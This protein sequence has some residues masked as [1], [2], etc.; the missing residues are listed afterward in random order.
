MARYLPD[1]S[2]VRL[3]LEPVELV[4]VVLTV[5]IL[6]VS[7]P[8]QVVSGGGTWK[9]A[10]LRTAPSPTTSLNVLTGIDPSTVSGGTER[11]FL[12]LRPRPDDPPPLP[13]QAAA[14]ALAVPVPMDIP[15]HVGRP[16][17]RRPTR[18]Q[19]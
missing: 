2:G 15:K 11:I 19:S 17:P 14:A 16:L 18:R 13:P 7:M 9:A 5:F 6:E 12:K 3:L 4:A 8:A 10:S 1:S